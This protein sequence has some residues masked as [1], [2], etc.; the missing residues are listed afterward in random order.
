M[1]EVTSDLCIF[2]GWYCQTI[3]IHRKIQMINDRMERLHFLFKL[4]QR[5]EAN[6]IIE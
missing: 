3:Q 1:N 6:T 5:M 2:Y 4:E